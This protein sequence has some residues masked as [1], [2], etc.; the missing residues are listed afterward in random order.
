MSKKILILK[1]SPREFGNSAVLA[2]QVAKGANEAGAVVE[3]FFLAGMDIRPCDGC[4]FCRDG[5]ACIIED[6]MQKLY[7]KLLQA[8]VIV[9]ASPI[10]WFTFNA[11]LKTCIDRWYSLWLN[12]HDAFKGKKFGFVLTYGDADLYTSGAI[13][14]IHTY[15][16]MCRFLEAEIGGWVYGTLSDIGDAQK[17][18]GMME[19]AY[20]LGLKLVQ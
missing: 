19:T 8:D 2:D 10:Y 7:P 16:T 4:D 14:A 5:G 20:Q 17:N 1:S 9:L 13:N 3:S 11:Q 6:D 18:P 12:Q 15:E